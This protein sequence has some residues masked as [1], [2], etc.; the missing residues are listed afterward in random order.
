MSSPNLNIVTLLGSGLTYTSAYLFGIP[1][2]SLLSGDSVEKLIQVSRG[3]CVKH[4]RTWGGAR[5]VPRG[6]GS[7]PT[8]GQAAGLVKVQRGEGSPKGGGL[9]RTAAARRGRGAARLQASFFW[10]RSRSSSKR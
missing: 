9:L 8:G 10:L 2:Q 7:C 3:G 4:S 5:E 6:E 1:E